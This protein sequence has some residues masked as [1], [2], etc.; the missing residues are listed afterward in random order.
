MKR[1]DLLVGL[2]RYRHRMD[3]SESCSLVFR[4]ALVLQLLKF[5][6]TWRWVCSGHR[7]FLRTLTKVKVADGGGLDIM[8]NCVPVA[9][10]Q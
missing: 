2:E 8:S 10:G 9:M 6:A 3:C 4:A 1:M 7:P 5:V